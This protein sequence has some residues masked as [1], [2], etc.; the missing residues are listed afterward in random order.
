M[1]EGANEPGAKTRKQSISFVTTLTDTS[2]LS[3]DP[4]L[5]LNDLRVSF[6]TFCCEWY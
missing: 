2:I 1:R 3:D 5:L 4:T 6:I